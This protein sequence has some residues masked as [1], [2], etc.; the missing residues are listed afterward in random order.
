M[1]ALKVLIWELFLCNYHKIDAIS[2]QR[3]VKRK[4]RILQLAVRIN[5]I[6]Y[7]FLTL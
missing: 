2:E 7:Q 4:E 5:T 6:D 1:I 3:E